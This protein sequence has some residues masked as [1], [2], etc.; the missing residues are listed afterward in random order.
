MTRPMKTLTLS[1][2]ALLMGYSTFAQ[3]ASS[4]RDY[5]SKVFKPVAE[6]EAAYYR[7]ITT[8]GEDF[9]GTVHWMNGTLRM[10]GFYKKDKDGELIKHGSFIYYYDNGNIE[11]SGYYEKG[12]KVGAWKRFTADGTARPD[13]YYNPESAEFIRNVMAGK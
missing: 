13:R 2:L 10:T 12:V 8:A 9:S 1:I 3:Q 7:D 4:D 6:A 11:S 5:L